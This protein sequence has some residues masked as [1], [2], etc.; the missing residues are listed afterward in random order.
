MLIALRR[1][2]GRQRTV[3]GCPCLG[4]LVL[5]KDGPVSLLRKTKSAD[6]K[7]QPF[8]LSAG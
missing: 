1:H 7:M 4:C 2:P 3:Q 5:D 8:I 6:L